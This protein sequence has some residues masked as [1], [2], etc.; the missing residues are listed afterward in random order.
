MVRGA[1]STEI[2]FSSQHLALG[3]WHLALS[4][5]PSA[6]AVDAIENSAQVDL[7]VLR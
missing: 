3:T 6:A 4:I 1:V 7:G 5:W 2:A